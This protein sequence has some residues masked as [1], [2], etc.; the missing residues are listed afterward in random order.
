VAFLGAAPVDE[1]TRAFTQLSPDT[2]PPIT[3]RVAGG[4]RFGPVIWAGLGGDVDRLAAL[5]ETVL[6]VLAGFPVDERPFQPHLTLS[7]RSDTT[8]LAALNSYAGPSWQVGEL[9]LV[10]S[11]NGEYRTVGVRACSTSDR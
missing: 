11:E 5:R 2:S 7:Y 3:L 8:L 6:G 1:V 9:V 4:G 10:H